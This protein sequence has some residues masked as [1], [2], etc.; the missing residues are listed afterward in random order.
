MARIAGIELPSNK[1][2]E[3]AFSA[4]Y[5]VGRPT[6]RRILARLNIAPTT[7]IRQM[8]EPQ[9]GEIRTII[10]KECV[11]EGALRQVIRT[12]IKRL[13]DTRSW[14]GHRHEKRL[15][16]RGQHTST[17]SRTIRGNVRITASG[18]SSKRSQA[19]PT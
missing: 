1:V 14:R 9:M 17:N 12:N 16:V 2:A 4:I 8:S 13:K 15:P 6:S 18:T 11:V 10:E 7:H 19:A 5:G 3:I